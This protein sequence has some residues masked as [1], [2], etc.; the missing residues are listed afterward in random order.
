M[1]RYGP[2]M[3]GATALDK[4][5]REGLRQK[6]ERKKTIDENGCWIW[7]EGIDTQGYGQMRVFG[8][9]VR[10]SRIS[11]QLYKGAITDGKFVCHTCDV[12]A[13]IN[14]AH[15]WLGTASDNMQDMIKKGRQRKADKRGGNNSNARFTEEDVIY[16]RHSLLSASELAAIYNTRANTIKRIRSGQRWPHLPFDQSYNS[17]VDR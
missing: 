11:Y 17:Q 4:L 7:P 2:C 15:L 12:R 6:L 9:L 1:N 16:I 8:V 14:P 5:L 3:C 13:C 10:V